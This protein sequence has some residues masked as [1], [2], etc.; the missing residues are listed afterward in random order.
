MVLPDND[1]SRFDAFIDGV[2]D[3]EFN[4][5]AGFSRTSGFHRIITSPFVSVSSPEAPSWSRSLPGVQASQPCRQAGH[6]ICYGEDGIPKDINV[7]I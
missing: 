4:I 3:G 1:L 7:E 6:R 5:C 2:T